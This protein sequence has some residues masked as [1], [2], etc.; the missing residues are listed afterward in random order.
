MNIGDKIR[1]LREEKGITQTELARLSKLTSVAIC[2]IEN[3]KRPVPSSGTLQKLASALH[4]TTDYLLSDEEEFSD[5]DILRDPNIKM[6][7]E[8]A[9]GLTKEDL[10]GVI[11]YIRYVKSQ[12]KKK[13]K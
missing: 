8:S 3:G 9:K 2:N 5:E 1:K 13:K 6:M 12:S 11:S 10:K 7:F 4:V